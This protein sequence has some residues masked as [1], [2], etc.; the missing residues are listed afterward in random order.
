M[1]NIFPR[2]HFDVRNAGELPD[3]AGGVRGVGERIFS[4]LL[5]CISH[6]A[7]YVE[8]SDGD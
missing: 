3:G 6:A 1:E 7:N 8:K 5:K 4:I 2:N